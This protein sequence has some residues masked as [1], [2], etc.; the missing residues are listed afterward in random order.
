VSRR[1]RGRE[2]GAQAVFQLTLADWLETDAE[3]SKQPT[4]V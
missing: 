2:A 4:T 3:R 1:H